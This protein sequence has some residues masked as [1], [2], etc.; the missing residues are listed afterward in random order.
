MRVA[1]ALQM[2]YIAPP[3]TLI[4]FCFASLTFLYCIN[5]VSL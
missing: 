1:Y 2:F 4:N 3:L 5:V